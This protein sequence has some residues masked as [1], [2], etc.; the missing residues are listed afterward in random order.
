[1]Q[2]I[3][4]TLAPAFYAA[5]IYFCL[6]R[7]VISFGADNSRIAPAKYPYIFITCDILSLL[8][9]AA[10]GG[11]AASA[12]LNDGSPTTG[13][14]VLIAGLSFQV[15]TMLMFIVLVA[16]FG[17]RTWMR[18]RKIGEEALDPKYAAMRSSKQFRG[19]LFALTFATMCIFARC[20]YRVAELAE[21]WGGH[22]MKTQAFFVSLE[23]AVVVAAV[24][25]LNISH[26]AFCISDSFEEVKEVVEEEKE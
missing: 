22:L 17:I 26:P 7:I 12:K 14:N 10:G 19:F 4:L 9:Q 1:M 25:A 11:I 13:A 2:I 16:D 5:G 20:V 18:V 8:L 3:G 23:G 21:G 6:S 15:F 24:L